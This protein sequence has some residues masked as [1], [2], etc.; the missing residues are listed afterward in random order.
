MVTRSPVTFALLFVSLAALGAAQTPKS[1]T[2]LRISQPIVS[3]RLT[4]PAAS[5]NWAEALKAQYKK[6]SVQPE[7][8]SEQAV[9]GSSQ[10]MLICTLKGRGDSLIIVSA[11]LDKDLPSD[12]QS[13]AWASLAML[14][15]LAESLNSVSTD[16]SILF[17][18]F[19]PDKHHTSVASWYVRSLSEA[20]RRRVKAAV[21]ISGVGRGPTSF[22]VKPEARALSEWLAVASQS[23]HLPPPVKSQYFDSTGFA[24][25]KSFHAANI[26]AITVSSDPQHAA[27]AW[28]RPGLA[29][30]LVDSN[31]YYA[32][33]QALCVFLVDLDRAARGES[34]RNSNSLVTASASSQPE[35]KP[36]QFTEDQASVMIMRQIGEARDQYHT[37][38][39]WPGAIPELH[40]LVCQM[41]RDNELN[42][43]PFEALL[44]KKKL[45]GNVAVFSGD[46]PSLTPQQL[47]GMK[48]TRYRKLAVSTCLVAASGSNP[49]YWIAALAY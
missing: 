20:D 17:I 37:N 39:L 10:K 23:L 28:N 25:A 2:F 4:P 7:Q 29:I 38:T 33:Y 12:R 15:L 3:Q 44:Q 41:A 24:D 5:E 34:P 46:Y 8:L 31:A 32:T 35:A 9:P 19:P 11:N 49:T 43:A 13:L 30:N 26:P 21:E 1:V 6:A 45:A 36:P 14:P 22:D 40:D 18:A 42:T 48:L 27:M 16:S 47:Q